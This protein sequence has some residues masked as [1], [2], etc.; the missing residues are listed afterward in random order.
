MSK[1]SAKV[2]VGIT[3]RVDKVA[4]RAEYR[5]ALDQRVVEWVNI[6]GFQPVPV[7]NALV[8][9]AYTSQHVEHPT[10]KEW[11]LTIRP[12]ALLLS[13]GNDVGECP[14]R[15]ATERHLLSWAAGNRVPVLGICRGLQMIAVWA[16]A[17]LTRVKNHVKV[18]HR[19]VVLAQANEWP[20]SVNSYHN[21][22]LAYCPN[23]FEAVAWAEDGVIEAIRHAKL[24][25]EGWMW[26][27]EREAQFLP[28]DS[29]RLKA[30]F[31]GCL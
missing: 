28:E 3:Q 10:L 7:P 2:L 31:R 13:G 9:N 21:W 6:A 1:P 24:S 19:L 12:S 11:L 22:G 17:A 25:W 27:P 29:A 5:D 30:L 23:G 20:K 18:H 4:G 15:D 26:H 8:D 16:G 14:Q